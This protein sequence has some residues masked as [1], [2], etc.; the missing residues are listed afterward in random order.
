[1][2]ETLGDGTSSGLTAECARAL[3]RDLRAALTAF[4]SGQG[5]I[6]A[7]LN[8]IERVAQYV[9][10]KHNVQLGS[11]EK[12]M[13]RFVET[14]ARGR[15]TDTGL[16][17]VKWK[18]LYDTVRHARN[19]L[20]HTGAEAA[21]AGTR[22]AALAAVLMEALTQAATQNATRRMRDVMVSNPTCAQTWQ[23]LADVR[24]TMLV[25]D[26]SVLPLSGG[27]C[28]GRW[29]SV[30]AEDLAGY[31]A[32]GD[33][34]SRS[35]ILADAIASCGADSLLSHLPTFDLETPVET[36]WSKSGPELPIVVTTTLG[37]ESNEA[38]I[39]GIVT[40]FDLL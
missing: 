26:F 24:R 19:D 33:G 8:E 21:L 30:R 14:H 20:A 2:A 11:A 22:T 25:N 36:I 15:L 1:M 34:S 7:V 38:E 39:A 5:G 27:H 23:T 32:A 35:E 37:E 3:K 12:R 6:Q 29:T 13:R 16:P 9:A 18:D 17:G 31:L 40:A 10:G 28:D 4:A